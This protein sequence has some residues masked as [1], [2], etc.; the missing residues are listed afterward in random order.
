MRSVPVSSR[1]AG[2][3]L[4]PP[5]TLP[6]KYGGGNQEPWHKNLQPDMRW[7]PSPFAA[8][9]QQPAIAGSLAGP[10]P[11]I[12]GPLAGPQRVN[13]GH[14]APQHHSNAHPSG[15][16]HTTF[17]NPQSSEPSPPR[18]IQPRVNIGPLV[19]TLH[20]PRPGAGP[21]GTEDQP[22]HPRYY[23]PGAHDRLDPQHLLGVAKLS[24]RKRAIYGCNGWTGAA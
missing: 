2:W 1:K 24:H 21:H 23:L 19:P 16:M 12:A 11:A 17:P 22:S 10:Q 18:P 14:S 7:Q 8:A 20:P 15:P 3:A 5:A 13:A 9:R 6:Q 4:T